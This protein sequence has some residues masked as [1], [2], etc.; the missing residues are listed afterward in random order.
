MKVI[1]RT[2]DSGKAKELFETARSEN[3]LIITENKR[4]LQA[5]AHGYGY[6]D[7]EII[8]FADLENCDYSKDKALFHNAEKF[9]D[10]VL[11]LHNI[12]LV[13]F[14]ATLEE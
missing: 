2:R 10:W 14:S 9:L 11:K 6:N 7:L 12:D 13:G 3:A 8:D 5:K 1:I 4:G